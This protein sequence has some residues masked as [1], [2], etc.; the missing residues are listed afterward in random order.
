MKFSLLASSALAISLEKGDMQMVPDY[1]DRDTDE[2]RVQKNTF[3]GL[4]HMPDGK[5]YDDHHKVDMSD[6][7]ALMTQFVEDYDKDVSK[8]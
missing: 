6:N 7:I 4:Y 3:D 5:V 8:I 2:T 1:Y